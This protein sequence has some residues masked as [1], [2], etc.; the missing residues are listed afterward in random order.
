VRF[1]LL[2]L[3]FFGIT[4][5]AACTNSVP[6]ATPR[7]T[8]PAATLGFQTLP[9]TWTPTATFT[10]APTRTATLTPTAVPTFTVEQLCGNF[11]MVTK[12]DPNI[13]VAMTDQAVFAWKGVPPG[14]VMRLYIH[15]QGTKAGVFV[16]MPTP[17][18]GLL[19]LPVTRLPDARHIEWSAWLVHPQYGDIC[20]QRGT[21]VRKLV[22]TF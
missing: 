14:T 15:E 19:P 7:P 4:L 10:P 3:T 1:F 2:L 21:F 8:T 18:D 11:S 20:V 12:P 17:G 22:M 6:A 9:P 5:L 16:E 13:E